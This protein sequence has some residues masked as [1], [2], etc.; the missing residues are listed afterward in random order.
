MRALVTGFTTF[1]E[2][3]VNPSRL[4]VE[5]LAH[6]RSDL[7][8]AVL[9]VAYR[10]AGEQIRSLIRQHEPDAVLMLGL[11]A[12]RSAI[13]LE[14]FALN[15]DDAALPDNAG[16]TRRGQVIAEGSPAAYV[17]TLPLDAMQ[18]LLAARDVPVV[19]SNHAGAYLCNHV[20]YAARH[21]L[22]QTGQAIPC[23]FIHV[24]AVGDA[25]PALPLAT[26]IDAVNCCLDVLS[27]T[28]P[29]KI[30]HQ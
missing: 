21:Y 12:R 24:P 15:I 7:V 20:F 13:N 26:L 9:P 16:E 6:Q 27:E 11:A 1:G 8:T 19:I 22:E 2:H 4:I 5:A 23:G 25:E 28:A 17:S 10:S 3:A 30:G 29:L 18:R 14:R